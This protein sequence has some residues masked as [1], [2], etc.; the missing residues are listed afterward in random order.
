VKKH[1]GGNMLFP[2]LKAVIREVDV[3]AGYMLLD[4]AELE[5]VRVDAD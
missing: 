2:A 3:A 1:D 4:G 5:K